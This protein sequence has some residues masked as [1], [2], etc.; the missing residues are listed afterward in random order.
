MTLRK[1]PYENIVRKG[2]NVG[3]QHYNRKSGNL[4]LG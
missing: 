1:V 4:Q 2:E 3:N